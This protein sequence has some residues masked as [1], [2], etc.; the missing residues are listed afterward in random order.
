MSDIFES[1]TEKLGL[2]KEGMMEKATGLLNQ[3][4]DQIPDPIEGKI[5][6]ALHGGALGGIF[7]KVGLGGHHQEAK[8]EDAEEKTT[9]DSGDQSE[10]EATDDAADDDSEEEESADD[11]TEK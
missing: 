10:K 2:D 4:R 9:E 5:E 11:D 8:A 7:D 1:V 3:H 6:E